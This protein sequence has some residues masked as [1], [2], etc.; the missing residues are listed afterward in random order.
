MSVVPG[1]TGV[2]SVVPG[3]TGVVSVVPGVTGVV[4]VVPGVT[5]VVSVVP[6]VTGV[7]SVVPGV[8]G[9]VSVVPGVGSVV[10]SGGSTSIEPPMPITLSGLPNSSVTWRSLN[11]TGIFVPGAAFSGILY[12]TVSITEPSGRTVPKPFSPNANS[13]VSLLTSSG[14]P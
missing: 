1:V 8:T 7:V 3:V 13:P 6:G 14:L 2:V 11:V 12:S 9:V 4:S 10:L 5:G